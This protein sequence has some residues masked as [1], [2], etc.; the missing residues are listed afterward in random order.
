M[1]EDDGGGGSGTG[2]EGRGPATT[3]PLW[4]DPI[5]SALVAGFCLRTRTAST[6]LP[7]AFFQP[8]EHGMYRR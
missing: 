5:E 3:N 8:I 1:G 2:H 6:P 4:K 7:K